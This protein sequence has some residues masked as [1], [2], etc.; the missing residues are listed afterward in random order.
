MKEGD[1]GPLTKLGVLANKP[2]RQHIAELLQEAILSSDLL[3]GK[4][5]IESEIATQFG[6]SR[7]PVREA[8]QP[9]ANRGVIEIVAYKGT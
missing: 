5:L 2:L 8:I 6:V 4:A 3:P 1:G 7:V 9:L